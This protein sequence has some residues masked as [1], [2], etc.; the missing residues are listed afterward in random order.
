LKGPREL[1]I[2]TIGEFGH[3]RYSEAC[4]IGVDAFVHTTRYSLD[5][6]P[7]KM[8]FA[9]ADN[10]F[11]DDLES[12]KWKYY[13]FLSK[14]KEGDPEIKEYSAVLGNSGTFI[15]PTQSLSYLDIPGARNPW[16][17]T[18]AVILDEKDI[19]NPAHKI[20]GKHSYSKKVQTA[21]NRTYSE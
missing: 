6:A 11:S 17:E 18:I 16:K 15:M 9:V 1:G 7:R 3:T 2:A 12:P 13:K 8:A 20:T 5:L 10:P 21:Y 19:N 14:L 4:R